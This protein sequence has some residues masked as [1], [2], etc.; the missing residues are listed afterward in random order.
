[1]RVLLAP[2]Y[3]ASKIA[4]T[5]LRNHDSYP[6]K[7]LSNISK[8]KPE[9]AKAPSIKPKLGTNTNKSLPDGS[10]HEKRKH[11]LS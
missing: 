6:T 3:A 1:M 4:P 8:I 5:M 10:G 2:E 7:S 9:K 11:Y